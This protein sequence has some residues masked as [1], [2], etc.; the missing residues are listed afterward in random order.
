MSLVIDH[1]LARL[2]RF[3]RALCLDS[4]VDRLALVQDT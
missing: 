3:Q 1:T 2:V 4:L